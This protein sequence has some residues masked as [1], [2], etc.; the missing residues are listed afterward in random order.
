MQKIINGY[1][2]KK[3]YVTIYQAFFLFKLKNDLLS[4]K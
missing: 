1:L 2:L 3:T 4:K